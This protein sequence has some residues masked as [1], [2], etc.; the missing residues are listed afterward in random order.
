MK[1]GWLNTLAFFG[2]LACSLAVVGLADKPR[3]EEHGAD[4]RVVRDATGHEVAVRRYARIVSASTI[5]DQVLAEILEPE[6]IAA[7]SEYGRSA[8]STPWRFAS[9]P[10]IARVEDVE[11]IL[12]LRPDLVFVSNVGD[13]RA[14]T[15]LRESG[16]R[17]FDLGAMHGLSTLL[18]DVR[19]IGVVVGEPARAERLASTYERRMRRVSAGL[20]GRA[21]GM[22]LGPYGTV[23]YGGARDTSYADVLDAAG[24]DDVATEAGYVGWPAYAPEEVLALAPDWVVTPASQKESLC[25]HPALGTLSACREGRVVGVDD[26]LLGD[27]GLSMLDAAEAI[28][29]AVHGDAAV[30]E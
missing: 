2:A 5:A 1:L 11:A 20:R 15:R 26:D 7:I 24:I 27:P 17:V 14:V 21:R 8:S 16:A 12:A 13:P 28:F 9:T 30:T 6:R 18:E 3:A 10:T 4:A 29:A 25:A 22:Y 19:Q 23:L